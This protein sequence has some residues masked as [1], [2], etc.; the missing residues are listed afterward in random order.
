MKEY[1][2]KILA[3][4]LKKLRNEKHLSQT[5]LSKL[6]HVSQQTVGSWETGRAIPGSDTLNELAD[7]FGTSTDELLGRHSTP[8]YNDD[9]LDEM[10]DNAHSY[11][12][13]PLDDHDR[14]LIR[15]YLKALLNK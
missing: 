3:N 9:D 11:D 6:L 4:N 2:R 7:Y 12:G 13:K 15:Q 8:T 5:E 14:E 1:D 10:L